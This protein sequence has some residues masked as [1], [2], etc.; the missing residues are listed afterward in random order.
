MPGRIDGRTPTSRP[1]KNSHMQK[2]AVI[3]GTAILSFGRQT[4]LRATAENQLASLDLCGCWLC[5]ESKA[6][7]ADSIARI[8]PK[9]V[10][11]RREIVEEVEMRK[12][13]CNRR[14]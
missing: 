5:E 11:S 13:R 12:E 6:N 14:R 4:I 1:R 3:K 10:D 9:E 8:M 2:H 7:F